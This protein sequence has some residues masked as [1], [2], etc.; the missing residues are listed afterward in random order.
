MSKNVSKVNEKKLKIYLASI[1][2]DVKPGNNKAAKI[3]AKP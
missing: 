2:N 3:S 1:K